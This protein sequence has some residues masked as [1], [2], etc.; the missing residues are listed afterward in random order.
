MS[1]NLKKLLETLGV[2][3]VDETLTILLD[4]NENNETVDAVLKAS[5]NY[6][7]P[8]LESDFNERLNNDR[9]TY[10]GKYLKEALLKAN[11]EFGSPL[12]NKE[13]ET[14]LDNPD[15]AGK[16]YDVAFAELKAK[17]MTRTGASEAE[18]QAMLDTAN[19]K[20]QEYDTRIKTMEQE[21]KAAFDEYVKTGKLNTKLKEKLV[22]FLQSRTSMSADKAAELLKEPLMKKALI[23]LND[24][25]ELELY[26]PKSPETKLKKSETELMKIDELI[27]GLCDEYE[28]PKIQSGGGDPKPVPAKPEPKNNYTAPAMAAAD[29]VAA[30]VAN[31]M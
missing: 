7:K 30:A 24:S 5:H 13:I 8:F 10:K 26:D 14:I 29:A 22:S 17:V 23:K 25:D 28:L 6:S 2:D 11:K 3:N 20:L 21:H 31:A 15:N 16:N 18:L 27:S 4:E 1:K 19:N 9:K 12:T